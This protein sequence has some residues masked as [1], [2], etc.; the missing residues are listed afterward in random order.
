M[1]EPVLRCE[2]SRVVAVVVR[3]A[4]AV[5]VETVLHLRGCRVLA[6]RDAVAVGVSQRVVL[7]QRLT[8]DGVLAVRDAVAVE[9]GRVLDPVEFLVGSRQVDADRIGDGSDRVLRRRRQHARG[10]ESARGEDGREADRG[11]LEPARAQ[12]AEHRRTLLGRNRCRGAHTRGLLRDRGEVARLGRRVRTFGAQRLRGAHERRERGEIVAHRLEPADE[13]AR[14]LADEARL[15]AWIHRTAQLATAWSD[16][17]FTTFCSPRCCSDFTAPV[18]FPRMRA[19]SS[20][21]SS[22]MMRI[23]RTSR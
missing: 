12:D 22:A 10:R 6:V 5:V 8:R 11:A 17:I 9:V 14:L 20:S 16:R 15:V 23:V 2:L 19:V 13:L 4:V 7:R 1:V 21:G 18:V 3:D